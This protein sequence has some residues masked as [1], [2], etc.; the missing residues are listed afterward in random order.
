MKRSIP[1]WQMAGFIAVSLL[2]TF[3][4]FLFDLTGGSFPAA[5][6]SAVNESIWEHMKLL[7]YPM[8]L[9]ALVENRA[10][11]KTLPSFWCIKLAGT[12]LGLALIP[13]LYYTYTGILGTSA[14][15][16]NI[17]I[18]FL[19]AGAAFRWETTRFSSG[20]TCRIQPGAAKAALW[21]LAAAFTA[22]T[23]FPPHLPFFADPINGTYGF[24]QQT[25]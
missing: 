15:W 24:Y 12:L 2:G 1:Q 20:R 25:K 8:M 22:A 18:F 23:F 6:V 3:L 21:L 5:L 4:H 14:D 10:W 9:V 17:A 7:F 16:F 19:A 13:V 11:G